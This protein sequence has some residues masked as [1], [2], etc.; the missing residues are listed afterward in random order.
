MCPDYEDAQ[1]GGI[2]GHTVGTQVIRMAQETRASWWLEV[3]QALLGGPIR[4]RKTKQVVLAQMLRQGTGLAS[5]P[6]FTGLC[7]VLVLGV[8]LGTLL[9]LGKNSSTGLHPKHRGVFEKAFPPP[10]PGGGTAWSTHSRPL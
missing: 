2:G 4:S 7:F 6:Y 1:L 9:L 5:D 3:A 8:E 10:F